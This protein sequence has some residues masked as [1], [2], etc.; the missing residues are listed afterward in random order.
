MS[1]NL[2]VS[3]VFFIVFVGGTSFGEENIEETCWFHHVYQDYTQSLC[4][5]TVSVDLDH[6]TLFFL[7]SSH[8]VLFERK[9]QVWPRIGSR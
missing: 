7:L 1:L 6:L 3:D 8:V 5:T 4:L 9:P 2:D